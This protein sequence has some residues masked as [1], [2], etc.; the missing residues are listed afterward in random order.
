MHSHRATPSDIKTPRPAVAIVGGDSLLGK[1][2]HELFDSADLPASVSLIASEESG[3]S[4]I[5][6]IG[7][8][9]P[10]V[11]S[12]LQVADLATARIV[13][14]AGSRES[15]QKAFER[16]QA[17]NPMA[18]VIDLNGSLEEQPAATLRA[19][20]IE[21]PNHSPV[22]TIQVIAHPAAIALA[23]LLI[24]LRN[25]GAISRSVVNIFEPASERGKAGI[26]EL[27]K[28][29]VGLLSFKPHP[30]EVYDAQVSFNMLSRYGSDSPHSL[31][32]I[33]LKIDRHLATLLAGAGAL[34]MPSLRLIQAPVFHGYSMSAW[35]E[36]EDDPGRDAILQALTSLKIDLR[37]HEEEP[38]T[39]VG[40]A[41][42]SGITVG[43]IA[44]DRNH[45]RAHWFWMVA[46]NLRIT[47]E[48]A[49]E[50]ARVFLK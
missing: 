20:L 5:I 41:G 38:P 33:E 7:H 4:N 12:S 24:H 19:P 42:Q 26:D 2:V 18:T 35:V 47:A 14:L 23:L 44:P 49:L 45:P 9:E 32:D 43:A 40:V 37:A 10:V 1:E 13:L 6:S 28:Q 16:V 17:V 29:T 36:F 31:E 15:S 39:N 21:P 3:D 50:V 34:G 30:K 8:D 48:N 27:Q 25:A 22:G 46:D 11:I